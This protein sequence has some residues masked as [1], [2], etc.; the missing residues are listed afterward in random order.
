VFVIALS[1]SCQETA[2]KGVTA[3]PN[4]LWISVE[5]LSLRLGCY[6]DE[7]AR[8]P[9]L[10]Q[11]AADGVRYEN[12]FT[13]AGVC[14]PS[15]S[16][17]ITGMYQNS[18]GTHHMRTTHVAEG[19]PT[20]YFAVPP[21]QVKA[22]TEYLRALGYFCTNR[23]KTDYQ[24]GEPITVWD[25]TGGTAH[26]RSRKED[27]PF[28]SVFN[29]GTTHE[30]QVWPKPD[31][32]L[33]TDPATVEIPPYYPDT[34]NVREDLARHCDNIAQ[35]D[36][37]VHE[38]LRQLEED[39]LVE[40]TVVFF[41]SDHGDGLPRAKRW[42]YDSG[43]RVPLIIRWPGK[44][45]PATVNSDL[46]SF[47]DLAPTVL[48][49]AGIAAP[50][51]LQGQAFLGP[52][53]QPPREYVFGAR[54]RIDE[55]YDWVRAVRDQ[56]FKLI[57]NFYPEKPYVLPVPYR[58]RGLTMQDLLRMDKESQLTGP[59]RI[60]F[61]KIR[62]P[63]ELYDL[64]TDP[65]EIE[66]LI[67][68]P[69]FQP[70]AD[71]LREAL[72]DWMSEIEDKGGIPESEMVAAMWPGGVQPVTDR[73]TANPGGGGF[74]AAVEVSIACATE[75]ASIAYT[76]EA[77]DGPHWRLY[78]KPILLDSTT[79]LRAKAVRYGYQE[80]EELSLEYSVSGE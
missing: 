70:V 48:S 78:S 22:F 41:F 76:L 24:F 53:K 12:A 80:S 31:R 2:R 68:Q 49:I 47:V 77:G 43:L 58:N 19:L 39:N 52:D 11:L 69:E 18:I 71:R 36:Q 33:I 5:D 16:A 51:H 8:T 21:P 32:K 64:E 65:H 57:R 63:E 40:N 44:L 15:R 74:S 3:Q 42:L 38:I 14:A 35:M 72:E 20:P 9:T 45:T 29:F 10:N 4:I 7:L 50:S 66:N 75:G 1:P 28:F 25:E 61:S 54:D 79:R 13:T 23:A 67:A 27:Q 37:Q 30:S 26:W 55:S 34:K 60:W 59:Q 46:V 56:K 6:G 17:I 62:P 73:P